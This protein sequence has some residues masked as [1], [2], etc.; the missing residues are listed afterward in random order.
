[1]TRANNFDALRLMAAVSVI[2][3][4]SFLIAEGSQA[5]EPFN[6]LNGNQAVLGLAGVFVFFAISGYLVTQSFEET[7]HAG[8]FLVKRGLR[9]FPGLFVA[10][11]VSAFAIAP[12]VATEP[13]A[14]YLASPQPWAY[15]L[16]NT[17]LLDPH[18]RTLPGVCFENNPV[19][20]EING[21][22]WSL[23]IEFMMY[24]MV[25]ALGAARLL[26]LPTAL[27][28]LALGIAGTAFPT[29]NFL[30]GWGWMLGFFAAGMVLYKLRGT[31]IWDGRIAL[32]ALVGLA[33]SIEF[34]L[35]IPLFALFGCYLALWLA[36][37]RRLPVVPAAAWGDLSY[38]LY[39][40]GW[41]VEQ[42]LSWLSGG[43]APWW[44]LFLTG[45]PIAAALAFLSWHLVERPAL[46]LKPKTAT[47]LPVVPLPAVV[48]PP[49]A[50]LGGPASA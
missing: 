4:H 9:I 32:A 12:L 34:R 1:M 11:L 20:L 23:Q 22:L 41:P 30:G 24:L 26:T 36:L 27:L 19:G 46:C 16:G 44:L 25:L 14:R 7:A 17:T 38:G 33:F 42:L 50:R 40:Y 49:P 43:K 8:R 39:I 13:L 18:L 37:D 3:S 5:R 15:V 21:S 47:R 31:W 28:L 29:L 10:T 48:S 2:F 6:L 35:F 45:L